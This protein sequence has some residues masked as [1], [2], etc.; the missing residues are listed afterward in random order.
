MGGSYLYQNLKV[1]GKVEELNVF[2]ETHRNADAKKEAISFE[3]L[4]PSTI[5]HAWKHKYVEKKKDYEAE[6]LP[7]ISLHSSDLYRLL[8]GSA[9]NA[10]HIE[11][12]MNEEKGY[13]SYHFRTKDSAPMIWY[14][15]L[16]TTYKKL[17]F[18][19]EIS[20]EEC[21]EWI[22]KIIFEN[23]NLIKSIKYNC[24]DD[25]YEKHGGRNVVFEKIL[26]YMKG[27][28]I[29]YRKYMKRIY[30]KHEK[31]CEGDVGQI[32][33]H[34]V[35]EDFVEKVKL[36]KYLQKLYDEDDFIFYFY[37]KEFIQYVFQSKG[38]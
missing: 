35:L 37:S 32:D 6:V 11:Y 8:W 29:D 27:K 12:E 13:L 26:L 18:E 1:F 20:F 28:S 17:K 25:F 34:G 16:A 2:Y 36:D 10:S 23:G 19:V 33:Y 14:H 3:K 9:S 24:V 4:I 7:N 22:H 15:T 5:L 38:L 21:P 31:H 30:D